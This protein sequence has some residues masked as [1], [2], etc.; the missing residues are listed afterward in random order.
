MFEVQ[1]GAVLIQPGESASFDIVFGEPNSY[2]GNPIIQYPTE[3]IPEDGTKVRFSVK[4]DVSKRKC[5]IQKDMVIWN[6]FVTIPLEPR[7]TMYL[8]IGEYTWDIR[9]FFENV[10]YEDPNT[11]MIPFP[12]YVTEVVG[13]VY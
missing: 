3:Q 11:P 7:D 13:N 5:V 12:F 2:T 6:G 9:L 8:P 1:G 4:V 10:D